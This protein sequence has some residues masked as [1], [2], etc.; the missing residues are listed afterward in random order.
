MDGS[1]EASDGPQS[2]APPAPPRRLAASRAAGFLGKWA[3]LGL[4]I[5][6]IAGFAAL[7]FALLIQ[8]ATWLFLDRVVGYRSNDAG[9]LAHALLA[10]WWLLPLVTACGGLVGG[11]VTN[12]FAPD[13]AGIGTDAV[14]KA[15]HA[16]RGVSIRTT[17]LKMATA[18]V[19]IGSGGTSGIEGPIAQVGAGVASLVARVT[20]LSARERTIAMAA[21]LGAG[22]SAAFKAPLAGALIAAEVFYREDFEVEAIVPALFASVVGYTVVGLFTSFQPLYMTD[23]DPF[24]FGNPVTLLLYAVLGVAAALMARLAFATFFPVERLF[25]RLPP[26]VATTLGGFTTGCLGLVCLLL[27]GVPLVVG[28]G[29]EWLQNVLT[30]T[31]GGM[32]GPLPLVL[33]L[34]AAAAAELLGSCLTIGSGGSGGIFGPSLVV[35]GFVGAALGVVGHALA[36]GLVPDPSL[37]AIVGMIAYFAAVVKAPVGTMVMVVEMTG[38][39]GLLGPAMVAVVFSTLLSGHQSLFRSQVRTRL[40]SPAK[41]HDYEPLVLRSQLV[42][43]A[44]RQA[45]VAAPETPVADAL[46]LVTKGGIHTLPVV[47][48]GRIVGVA[49]LRDLERLPEWDLAGRTVADVM[50]RD[51]VVCRPTDDLFEALSR[52]LEGDR[53]TLPVVE[54]SG[55][56]L[57]MVG[58]HD[59]ARVLKVAR[60]ESATA[61][62]A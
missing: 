33:M 3:A 52:M 34:L 42:R 41:A 40:Q 54:E 48:A 9:G 1:K 12:R 37:F 2:F 50:T 47:T 58:R 14:I 56:F 30:T 61:L 5:G 51:L 62:P 7:L 17:L 31:G 8:G 16:G 49:T 21:G 57:G 45:T 18:A 32:H 60:A 23:A 22:I 53:H 28:T 10:R 11:W 43:D 29:H 59:L 35:G 27:F 46:R 36:P 4:F 13:A 55:R 24:K 19:T 26:V 38:G 25:A 15:F 44:M 20:H 6:V 39:W